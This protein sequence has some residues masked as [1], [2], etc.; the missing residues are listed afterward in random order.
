ME[1]Q[2][3][4]IIIHKP[5]PGGESLWL[6]AMGELDSL[7]RRMGFTVIQPASGTH[8]GL[9]T[10]QV[11]A[12]RTNSLGEDGMEQVRKELRDLVYLHK[13]PTVWV[14]FGLIHDHA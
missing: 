11:T 3:V 8:Y 1:Q 4:T 14:G 12:G 7:V 9:I 10:Y 13:I 5:S 2:M 6:K